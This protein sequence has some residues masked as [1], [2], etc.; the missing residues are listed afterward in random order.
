MTRSRIVLAALLAALASPA[1]ADQ[2][3]AAD[4]A[5]NPALL[6][7]SRWMMV[8]PKGTDCEVP[9]E[10]DFRKDGTIE[11]NAGCNDF[12]GSWKTEGARVRIERKNITSRNCG[13][14]FLKLEQAFGGAVDGAASLKADGK[15]LILVSADGKELGR[16]TP[17]VAGSCD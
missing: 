3:P 8:L 5:A 2:A 1:F 17:V 4:V 16:V 11:G 15:E 10:I 14:K 7:G 13:E 6:S 9:P 12:R